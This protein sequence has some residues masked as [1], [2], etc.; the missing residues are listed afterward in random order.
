M[1]AKATVTKA[2]RL[3]KK[4]EKPRL[5][6]VAVN[7]VE[8]KAFILRNCTSLRKADPSSFYHK[9]YITPDLT[10]AE[11]EANHQ[12]RM[13]LKEMNKDGRLYKRKKW[14]DSAEEGVDLPHA[15]I[16][17]LTL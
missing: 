1:R 4:S 2:I 5:L 16:I 7:T 8:P 6:K 15:L 11:R 12:L 13:K 14:E 10:P 9:I 3:E 17:F